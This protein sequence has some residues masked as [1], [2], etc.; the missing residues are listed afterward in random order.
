MEEKGEQQVQTSH[1]QHHR[2]QIAR[3]T[4]RP[5]LRFV[6]EQQCQARGQVVDPA[7]H[8][9]YVGLFLTFR[10]VRVTAIFTDNRTCQVLGNC[11]LDQQAHIAK[12]GKLHTTPTT[13]DFNPVS[14]TRPRKHE[15]QA[16]ESDA[17][18]RSVRPGPVTMMTSRS[19]RLVTPGAERRGFRL[20]NASRWSADQ[21]VR[22]KSKSFVCNDSSQH[23]NASRITISYQS[24]RPRSL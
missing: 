6:Q 22:N 15:K 20:E 21:T 4:V 23:L 14:Q 16:V 18:W 2:A 12:C 19:K 17:R 5:R 3:G 11:T 7:L 10:Q 9:I 8:K 1:L 13:T 24:T